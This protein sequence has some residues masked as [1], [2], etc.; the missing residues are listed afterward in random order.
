MFMDKCFSHYTESS[1]CDPNP[2]LHNG[3]CAA[4]DS[5]EGFTCDCEGTGYNGPTCNRGIVTIQ[6]IP[7]IIENEPST[8]LEIAASPDDALT[9]RLQS[10]DEKSL[11]VTPSQVT[12]EYPET[13]AEFSIQG[14]QTGRYTLNY[15]LSGRSADSFATPE[16][17]AI[18]VT[19]PRSGSSFRYFQAVDTNRGILRESCCAPD[20]SVFSECP[21]STDEVELLSTCSWQQ[22]G[23]SYTTSGVVFSQFSDLSLPLS[24]AG[25]KVTLARNSLVTDLP[26]SPS[27]STCTPCDANQNR[28]ADPTKRFLPE[29]EKCYYYNSTTADLE[30]FLTSRSL[31]TT[32]LNRVGAI[33]PSWIIIILQSSGNN[34][35]FNIDDYSSSLVVPAN[36]TGIPGCGEIVADEPG[37][38]SVLR[39]GRSLVSFISGLPLFYSP[40]PSDAPLC[41]AVNLCSG[42]SSPVFVQLPPLVQTNIKSLLFLRQYVAHGWEFTI[43]SAAIFNTPK[44][45]LVD[46][47]YWNGSALYQPSLPPFDLMMKTDVTVDFS[48]GTL[49]V[50]FDFSGNIHYLFNRIMVSIQSHGG[51]NCAILIT[52]VDLSQSLI[53]CIHSLPVIKC[54]KGGAHDYKPD[55]HVSILG[56]V[57]PTNYNSVVNYT[58]IT[59]IYYLLVTVK[60]VGHQM[61]EVCIK[62]TISA[63]EFPAL[64]LYIASRNHCIIICF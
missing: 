32:Y 36:L 16:D 7:T 25:I 35:N 12:I 24:I 51:K 9:V 56:Q 60:D 38:Y 22:S 37:L 17:S 54:M 33:L 10:N 11:N 64:I 5:I 6:S 47:T 31:G 28:I 49:D 3:T 15:V 58:N 1:I 23:Q 34:L 30:D 45:I 59:S 13:K 20:N 29:Y 57:Q 19:R 26:Q 53:N 48:S 43:P 21:M 62:F 42:T 52:V 8:M 39:Y 14:K 46:N 44:S 41:F 40:G 18:F 63:D 27:S 4:V 55:A 61:G 2:C 50:G